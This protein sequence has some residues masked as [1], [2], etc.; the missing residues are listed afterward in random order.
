MTDDDEH[1]ADAFSLAHDVLDSLEDA[2]FDHA[3]IASSLILAL[4]ELNH[5]TARN[6]PDP[7][8]EARQRSIRMFTSKVSESL[9]KITLEADDLYECQSTVR[10]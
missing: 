4:V 5:A 10:H 7:N 6:L 8:Y 1:E 3:M 2:G 9:L